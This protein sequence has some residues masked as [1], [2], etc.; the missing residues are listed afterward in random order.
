MYNKIE[1]LIIERQTSKK[2]IATQLN[3]SYNTLLL[4]LKNKSH[5]TYDEA[6]Q[7]KN[8]LK[9]TLTIEEL[10]TENVQ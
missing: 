1:S 2:E 5:F 4:K 7:I 6:K 10:F 3:I 9:T 8:I